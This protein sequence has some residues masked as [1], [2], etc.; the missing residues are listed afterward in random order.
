[1]QEFDLASEWL[2]NTGKQDISPAFFVSCVGE[3]WSNELRDEC[4]GVRIPPWRYTASHGAES[5][6][7]YKAERLLQ[8]KSRA[9][10]SPVFSFV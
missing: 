3:P 4:R 1:M 6:A 5:S 7:L 10:D 8:T 9:A 2:T